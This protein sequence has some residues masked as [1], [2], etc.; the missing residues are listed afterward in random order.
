MGEAVSGVCRNG[1]G[2]VLVWRAPGAGA[3]AHAHTPPTHLSNWKAR[4]GRSS[5]AQYAFTAS[6]VASYVML[7]A[8][9]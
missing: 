1:S 4:T 9:W 8:V 7:A 3:R 6:M 2:R 5:V